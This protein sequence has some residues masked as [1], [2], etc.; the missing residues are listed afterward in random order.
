M[1]LSGRGISR[2]DMNGWMEE[3]LVPLLPSSFFADPVAW[4]KDSGAVA[5]KDS[6]LRWAGILNLEGGKRVF[7]KR[8]LTK[9]WAESLKLL[10]LPSKA[11]REW[12]IASQARRR[13]VNVP[14]PL[15]WMERKNRGFVTESYYLSQAIVPGVPLIDHPEVLGE[16]E[17]FERLVKTVRRIHDSGIL[18]LDFHAG[19]FLWDGEAFI[20]IDLHR[21]RILSHLSPDQRLR[22]LSELFHSMRGSWGEVEHLR[23]LEKYFE[24]DPGDG[25]RKREHLEKVHI[26]MD[27]LRKRQWASRTK[28]CLKESTE[29]SIARR[30]GQRCRHRRDFPLPSV[31][32]AIERHCRILRENSRELVKN[33][34]EVSVSIFEHR[35][36]RISVKQ[37]RY[38][39][40]TDRL[41]GRFRKSKALKAWV[42]G[43]GL[44]ARGVPSLRPLA[45][46]EKGNWSGLK[47]TFFLMEASKK[48]LEMDRYVLRGFRDIVGKRDFIRT[49]ARWLSA[50]HGMDLYHKDMKTC[51]ILVED[52]DG[53]W[54]FLLLDLEDV[55][56]RT[57]VDEGKIFRSFL[58]LNTSIPGTVTKRD[59]MFFFKEYLR[60]NPIIRD[61]RTFL[62]RLFDKSRQRG[63]VYVSPEG[64][65]EEKW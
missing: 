50:F 64:V 36:E 52:R 22:T 28:R 54:R 19:N 47:E 56:L 37:F 26:R 33:S 6:R 41:R 31:E 44:R 17:V 18:H 14:V 23:F 42:A 5:V 1:D 43:N 24:G 20:L 10:L 57:R 8:D 30:K 53:T 11:R 15:G 25:E 7:L 59:R 29:F 51:N 35:E 34:P 55:S 39:H 12:F 21:A 58:Q 40:L 60:H 48:G 45:L 4:A 46:V 61:Q 65:V 16:E 38:L 3:G 62:R 13:N 27:R 32:E 63:I 49:F 2:D 9:D